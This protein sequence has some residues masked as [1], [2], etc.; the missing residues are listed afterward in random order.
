MAAR[1]RSIA[2][3]RPVYQVLRSA[4]AFGKTPIDAG[5]ARN[6]RAARAGA[7]VTTR[8]R[9]R[10][11]AAGAAAGRD[12]AVAETHSFRSPPVGVDRQRPRPARAA[13]LGRG[14]VQRTAPRSAL[15][16]RPALARP[17][18]GRSRARSRAQLRQT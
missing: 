4:P 6:P 9:A 1:A 17:R 15:A 16:G 11:R 10:R 13:A 7:R 5:Q 14:L 18:R 8:A 3:T 2:Q 12:A